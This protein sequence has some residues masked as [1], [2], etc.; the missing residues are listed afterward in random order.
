MLRLRYLL[1]L[2]S[3]YNSCR[4]LFR[5]ALLSGLLEEESPQ[6][7]LFRPIGGDYSVHFDSDKRGECADFFGSDGTALAVDGSVDNG[8]CRANTGPEVP[9]DFGGTRL[10][11]PS[12]G[13]LYWRLAWWTHL[14]SESGLY[15]N[16]VGRSRTW[17]FGRAHSPADPRRT[18]APGTG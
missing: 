11:E 3:T 1:R 7:H 13:Q 2:Y 8:A 17:P 5:F 9:V 16:V 18:R 14:R 15:A 6:R 10:F 4:T 12:D